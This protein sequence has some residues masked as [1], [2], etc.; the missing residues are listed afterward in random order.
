MVKEAFDRWWEWVEKP[1][2]N[3]L[4]IPATPRG[5]NGFAARKTSG[6]PVVNEAVRLAGPGAQR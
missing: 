1:R 6:P 4:T 3:M 2:D 5:G